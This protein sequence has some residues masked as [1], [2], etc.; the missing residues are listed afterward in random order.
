MPTSW[1]TCRCAGFDLVI[2]NEVVQYFPS[3]DYLLRVLEGAV[4]RAAPGGFVFVGGVRNRELLEEF[5]TSVQLYQAPDGLS[6]AELRQRVLSH[7]ARE[8]ELLVSPDLWVALPARL[9]RVTEVGL[10]LKGGRAVNELTRF[11]YDVVLRV[12]GDPRPE[13][14]ASWLD[15]RQE[16]L[17]LATLRRRLAGEA[18][19]ALGVSGIPNRRLERPDGIDPAD[20][21]D[22]ERE[23]P[24]RVDLCW[25]DGGGDGRFDAL[26]RRLDT[27][28]SIVPGLPC[29]E[30]RPGPWSR[31]ANNPLRGLFADSLVPRLRSFLAGRL[32]EPMLPA[33]WVLLDAMPLTANGKVDRRALPPPEE[34]RPELAQ[35]FLAPRNAVEE[36]LAALWAQALRLDHVGVHDNFFELGGDSILAMQIISRAGR[37]GL[38]LAPRQMFQYQTIAEL[39]AVAGTA[40]EVRV[41]QGP[42]TGPVELTPIERWFFEQE[43]P[44][45]GHWNWNV[46]VFF[47]IHRPLDPRLLEGAVAALLHHHDALRLRFTEDG[48]WRQW[49]APVGGPIPFTR[50]DL[51]MLPEIAL[52]AA[53]PAAA[54]QVHASLDLAGPLLRALS[55]DR[56][57]DREIGRSG[58]LLLAV[59]HLV[60]D[61]VSWRLLL[62]D[63][64][65][66]YEQLARGEEPRLPAKTT[67]F[68]AWARRLVEHARS[69]AVESELP[70][71][72]SQMAGI[73]PLPVNFTHGEDTE[74][75]ADT[76]SCGL[77]PEETRALL[78]E[79]HGA[80][81]TRIDDL[82][83]TALAAAFGRWT[84]RR[85]LRVDLE[86]H[87][88]DHRDHAFEDVDLART[89][90]WFTAMY[91]AFLDPG[92]GDGSGHS[93]GEALRAV[94]EQA[95]AV[96]ASGLGFGLLRYL[97]RPEIQERLRRL[98]RA[99]VLF[100]YLGQLGQDE[101]TALF[102][103]AP[104]AVGPA[105]DPEGRRSHLLEI[106]AW[107]AGGRLRMEWTYSR[108]RHRRSTVE[109]LAG[110]FLEEL[111]GLIRHCLDP[112]AGGYT[113]SDFPDADLSQDDLDLLL[114][115][116][117]GSAS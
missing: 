112:E 40:E 15:W 6:P 51:S 81:Q 87:G 83:R 84:G 76:V 110:D 33:A 59:H 71:W 11:R 53:L 94:K 3:V 2:I 27:E 9:P 105:V 61:G 44:H 12:E 30:V 75:S 31:W 20:L 16:G 28:P 37:E 106:N 67:S 100:N 7:M 80:Y 26:F 115:R 89:V 95:R 10:Q 14:E 22:L 68:Q 103:P 88:R 19:A 35:A 74:G 32:P 13:P 36:Q 98:P 107:V 101:E 34:V 77:E 109:R 21:W 18:P 79:V 1:R 116:L 72:E 39:A 25:S 54:A 82:L 113:V 50:I 85:A 23:L 42:V 97:G 69:A 38:R 91:P 43:I 60:M 92:D 4:E 5:H 56:G 99:E 86:S 111:R 66:A 29:R 8:K 47:E 58:R 64:Q 73:D 93:P 114:T 70:Y 62:E 96:P 48:G 63:F 108:N 90:G 45:R 65:T 41:A 52:A 17:T 57:F 46:A 117:S 78:Q 104:E 24:Y 102:T 55:F 49:N